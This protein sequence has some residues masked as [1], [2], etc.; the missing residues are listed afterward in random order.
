MIT[1]NDIKKLQKIFVTKEEHR[2]SIERV[3]NY[4]NF[5][6]EPLDKIERVVDEVENKL[7]LFKDEILHEVVAMREELAVT[8]GHRDMLEDHEI[9]IT[10]LEKKTPKSN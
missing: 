8:L 7:I 2:A 6:L 5:R 1:D 10:K 4:I 3:I 9:R